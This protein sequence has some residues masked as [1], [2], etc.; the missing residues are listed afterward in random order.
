MR[1]L[2][3]PHDLAV[4]GS[5][6]NALDLGRGCARPR[7]R[8]AG[9]RGARPAG[10]TGA[11]PRPRVR[12]VR[13]GGAPSHPRRRGGDCAGSCGRGGSTCCT[14]T[15]GHRAWSATSRRGARSAVAVTTVL[16]MAAAPFLPR[17]SHLVVGTEQIAAHERAAGRRRTW[18]LEPSVDLAHD[19]PDVAL[20]LAGFRRGGASTT[21]RPWCA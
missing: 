12:P 15:S 13:A 18:V 17:S 3:Y 5:Q 21:A 9:S 1:V 20:D 10:G 19:G 6:L 16:S 8:G 4:G 2:V 14:A 7:P 11:R